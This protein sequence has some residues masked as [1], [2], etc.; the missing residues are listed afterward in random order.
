M[1]LYHFRAPKLLEDVENIAHPA[2]NQDQQL[3]SF[4]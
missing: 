2:F 3:E 4:R 1:Q